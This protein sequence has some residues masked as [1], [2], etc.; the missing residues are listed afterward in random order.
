MY[1][2]QPEQHK[3]NNKRVIPTTQ[4]WDNFHATQAPFFVI[5]MQKLQ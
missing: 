5:F 1:N 4:K 3:N 2:P